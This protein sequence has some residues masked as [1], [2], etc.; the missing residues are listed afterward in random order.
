[1]KEQAYKSPSERTDDLSAWERVEDV[2]QRIRDLPAA[3]G[4]MESDFKLPQ[5]MTIPQ[6]IDRFQKPDT[7]VQQQ[8]AKAVLKRLQVVVLNLML[9]SSGYLG[10]VVTS[11]VKDWPPYLLV[12]DARMPTNF[13][14]MH[15]VSRIPEDSRYA[16]PVS[17]GEGWAF[18]MVDFEDNFFLIARGLSFLDPT[19]EKATPENIERVRQQDKSKWAQKMVAEVMG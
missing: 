8:E 9:R 18:R 6:I 4:L 16:T 19:H 17:P 11:P 7:P 13:G 2:D 5:Q 14:N 15:E 1:M 3:Y 10:D 12:G